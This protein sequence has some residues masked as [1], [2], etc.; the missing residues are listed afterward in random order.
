MATYAKI[1]NGQVAQVVVCD[2]REWLEQRLGGEWV[3]TSTDADQFAGIGMGYDPAHPRH[4]ARPWEQPLEAESAYPADSYVYH[5]GKIWRSLHA[6]NVHA[7]G[8]SGWREWVEEGS[9]AAWVQPA[10]AH[11]AYAADAIVTH[12]GQT[13]TNNHGDGNVWEPGVF[14]WALYSPS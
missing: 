10:G 12:N 6:A 14:G 9:Y 3:E 1:E 2:S 7:P 4:F 11:D 8:V 13:W 5:N